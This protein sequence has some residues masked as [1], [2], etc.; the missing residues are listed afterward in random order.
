MLLFRTISRT[1]VTKGLGSLFSFLIVVITAR[2]MGAE[3]RGEISL[4]VLNITVILLLNDILG[5]G[6]MVFL[7]PRYRLLSLLIP[8][9]IWG[10][11]CGL[12]FPLFFLLFDRIQM[13][14]YLAITGLSVCLNLSSI[15]LSALNGKEKI[16]ENNI[17]S[18]TQIVVLLA[19]L[20]GFLAGCREKTPFLFYFALGFSYLISFF[21][22]LYYLR[23][24]LIR[25]PV[26]QFKR[27][28]RQMVRGGFYVQLGN[29]VQLLNYR[30][31]FY[32]LNYFYPSGG[33]AMVGIYSTAA[34][35]CESVWVISNGISMVQYARIANMSNRKEA[36]E[37]TISLS[38]ISFLATILALGFLL[39]LPGSIFG[40][41]FGP[42]FI[43]LPGIVGLLSAGVCAFGL[44]SMY[45]HYFSGIGKMHVSSRGSLIGFGVTL[46]LGLLLVP[47]FGLTGAAITATCSY[48]TSAVYLFFRFKAESG[49]GVFELLM[50]NKGLF[51]SL[52]N[53]SR[54]VRN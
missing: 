36:Q 31:S 12:L 25:G 9:W 35:V 28:I 44:A 42:E 38:K 49:K 5:G 32:L 51:S 27:M 2:Y 6:A 48:L 21:L 50:P 30:L 43:Y 26:I 16:R 52:Q 15:N 10:M 3:G 19:L 18:L 41:L 39:C 20:L 24:D 29:S 40:W 22:S 4:I 8:S 14:D 17:V 1:V 11:V 47:R 7:V 33:K 46:I 54:N 13:R 53:P 37:L 45:S 23:T 34:S